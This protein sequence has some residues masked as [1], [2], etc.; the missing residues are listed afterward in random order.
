MDGVS[1]VKIIGVGNMDN[2]RSNKRKLFDIY[3]RIGGTIA[4]NIISMRPKD[5]GITEEDYTYFGWNF[6]DILS[7]VFNTEEKTVELAAKLGSGTYHENITKLLKD[8]FKPL[9]VKQVI[10]IRIEILNS[11]INDDCE[12]FTS[13]DHLLWFTNIQTSDM[14]LHF[15][16]RIKIVTIPDFIAS[17]IQREYSDWP[18]PGQFGMEER[19]YLIDKDELGDIHFPEIPDP[20]ENYFQGDDEFAIKVWKQLLGTELYG[21]FTNSLRQCEYANALDDGSILN[22]GISSYNRESA[23]GKVA[24]NPFQLG[25]MYLHPEIDSM[26]PINENDKGLPECHV[27]GV[28]VYK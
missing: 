8:G 11:V 16:K 2:A 26:Y 21:D 17:L 12:K 1:E 14:L 5:L 19:F 25:S 28:K 18:F 23:R 22:V 7:K 6:K 20:M 4:S 24:I 13:K 3:E 10:A 9:T 27:I 15:H